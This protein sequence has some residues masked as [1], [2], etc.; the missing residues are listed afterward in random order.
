MRLHIVDGQL[1]TLP[2]RVH[3]MP[4][5]LEEIA[6][7]VNEVHDEK[8]LTEEQAEEREADMREQVEQEASDRR[9]FER[10]LDEAQTRI[11]ELETQL[12]AS[13]AE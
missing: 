6:K 1:S 11:A 8:R 10:K 5:D 7:V 3:L 12:R 13:A 2:D 9:H 4:Y